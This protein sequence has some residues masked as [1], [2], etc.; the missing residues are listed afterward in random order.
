MPTTKELKLTI[1]N[2]KTKEICPPL[3][4]KNGNKRKQLKKNEL[5]SIIN[6]LNI[7]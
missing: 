5:I 7:K 3:S 4:K 6:R 2:Y 1:K